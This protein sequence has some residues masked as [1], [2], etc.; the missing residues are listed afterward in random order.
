MKTIESV[1][2]VSPVKKIEKAQIVTED[3]VELEIS[4]NGVQGNTKEPL[5]DEAKKKNE[6]V[7]ELDNSQG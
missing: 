5:E 4:Q 6:I 1:S 2:E 7:L 3:R